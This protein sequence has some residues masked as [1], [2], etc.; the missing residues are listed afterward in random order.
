MKKFMAV[1]LGTMDSKA[2]EEWKARSDRAE[3]EKAGM[4]AWMK[5]G[6]E[7]HD[8]IVDNG[9]PLGKTK[10]VDKNGISDTKNE[11]SGY[12]IVEAESHEEAAKLFLNHPHFSMFPGDRVEIMECLPMPKM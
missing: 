8:V 9:A 4:E 11:M 7:H 10:R 6:T 5:W 12:A 3:L 1:Y 2:M